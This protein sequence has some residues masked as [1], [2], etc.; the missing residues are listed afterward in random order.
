MEES[1][2][3]FPGSIKTCK[4][5]VQGRERT[6]G[7]SESYHGSDRTVRKTVSPYDE[8]WMVSVLLYGDKGIFFLV[9]PKDFQT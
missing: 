1:Y 9:L 2:R 3:L 5:D 7:A 6:G 4:A 8:A